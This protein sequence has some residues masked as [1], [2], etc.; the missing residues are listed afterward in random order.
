VKQTK[1]EQSQIN[2]SDKYKA[3]QA[4]KNKGTRLKKDSSIYRSKTLEYYPKNRKYGSKLIEI[5]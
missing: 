4:E 5:K 1:I 3:N 2:I